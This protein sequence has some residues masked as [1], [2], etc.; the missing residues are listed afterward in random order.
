MLHSVID[1]CSL[2][3]KEPGVLLQT[4]L[5]E[6]RALEFLLER[7]D[8]SINPCRYTHFL[9][10]DSTSFTFQ[11]HSKSSK[12]HSNSTITKVCMGYQKSICTTY[13]FLQVYSLQL[14]HDST[15]YTKF[16]QKLSTEKC[17]NILWLCFG[18]NYLEYL[19]KRN[20]MFTSLF[21]LKDYSIFNA[22]FLKNSVV[23]TN[24]SAFL[25]LAIQ[26]LCVSF[27]TIFFYCFIVKM[28]YC[29][30]YTVKLYNNTKLEFYCLIF[31]LYTI[32]FDSTLLQTRYSVNTV[33]VVFYIWQRHVQLCK[34]VPKYCLPYSPN[35]Y[36]YISKLSRHIQFMF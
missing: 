14:I 8:F 6:R 4:K 19:F 3:I 25:I 2:E 24:C 33:P 21:C 26:K 22:P 31:Q 15:Q 1:F 20:I 29:H 36:L 28:I 5:S 27:K 7:Q 18:I 11:K 9:V 30:L 35:F 12:R 16:S 10:R 23:I 34:K 13:S 17:S 32:P